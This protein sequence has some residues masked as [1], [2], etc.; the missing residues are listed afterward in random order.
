MIPAELRKRK[1]TLE[2]ARRIR[3]ARSRACYGFM[4]STLFADETREEH[5]FFVYARLLSLPPFPPPFPPPSI[6]NLG[7]H[8][9]L[10][11]LPFPLQL[12]EVTLRFMATA[13]SGKACRYTASISRDTS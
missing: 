4:Y 11:H 2:S 7:V 3:S 5:V 9:S 12:P 10:F 13:L 6:R 8:L 1:T